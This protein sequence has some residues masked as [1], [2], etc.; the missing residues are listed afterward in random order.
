MNRGRRPRTVSVSLGSRGQTTQDFAVGIGIFLL[1]V[2]FVFSYVPT[3]IT[4]FSASTAS[5]SAQA[6]RIATD[7]VANYSTETANE[8][9]ATKLDDRN[10]S[11]MSEFGIRQSLDGTPID[12][13]NV[14]IE[15]FDGEQSYTF[16]EEYRDQPSGTATRVITLD[17]PSELDE[18]FKCDPACRLTV[19]VW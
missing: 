9:N 6:D 10:D 8:L 17:D 3:L 4:P 7:I 16:G 5:D 18:D 11:S 12:R 19:R 13:V 1:A 15:S 2:A 14:T